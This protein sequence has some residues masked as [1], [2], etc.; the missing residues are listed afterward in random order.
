MASAIL[1]EHVGS[2]Q[3]ALDEAEHF[4][5][6]DVAGLVASSCWP[7]WR[8]GAV[9]QLSAT[10]VGTVDLNVISAATE[11]HPVTQGTLH[12][13]D[14]PGASST[15]L[16]SPFT[17]DLSNLRESVCHP[18]VRANSSVADAQAR[19]EDSAL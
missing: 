11:A 8:G 1:D 7:A 2:R 18:K 15:D 6:E 9:V 3:S 16:R 19:A 4:R 17:A 12:S 5:I 13:T 10:K 14:D